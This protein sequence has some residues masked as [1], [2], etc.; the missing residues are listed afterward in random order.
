MSKIDMKPDPEAPDYIRYDFRGKPYGA[1]TQA[2]MQHG[3]I[4]LQQGIVQLRVPMKE[5]E[6][7]RLLYRPKN[8]THEGYVAE[9]T[10]KIPSGS[11]TVPKTV[12][13]SNLNFSNLLTVDRQ[14]RNYLAF[15]KALTAR[16]SAANPAVNLITGLPGWRHISAI[17][18][19]A[20]AAAGLGF[21]AFS[22]IQKQ[23]PLMM[24]G[25]AVLLAAYIGWWTWRFAEKNKPGTFTA[26][27]L[28][29]RALPP[30]VV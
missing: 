26:D 13:L 4:Y 17:I 19:G 30:P 14:D 28:P 8:T 29:A 7:V 27:S 18:A 11:K 24:T 16:A 21:I 9:I 2:W 6:A 5:V 1:G 23:G 15:I 20:I 3:F 10:V 25:L 22:N 12:K